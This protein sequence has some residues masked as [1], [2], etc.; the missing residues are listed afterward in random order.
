MTIVLSFL[1]GFLICRVCCRSST[2]H[3][4]HA[5][6]DAQQVALKQL[7]ALYDKQHATLGRVLKGHMSQSE[8]IGRISDAVI[9]V[10]DISGLGGE[11]RKN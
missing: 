4:A 6:I 2:D 9:K 7:L 5:R 10:A 8:H 1:V 11:A 3:E